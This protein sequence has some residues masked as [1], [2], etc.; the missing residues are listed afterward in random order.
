MK[1]L[2]AALVAALL[3]PQ[4]P[5]APLVFGAQAATIRPAD[6]EAITRAAASYGG[7]PW[8]LT[9][10]RRTPTLSNGERRWVA[11]VYLAASTATPELRRGRLVSVTTA[12]TTQDAPDPMTWKVDDPSRIET[13]AQVT[14]PGRSFDDVQSDSDENKPLV[15]RGE[16]TDADLVSSVR[17]LR[18]RPPIPNPRQLDLQSVGPVR[19]ILAPAF[20]NPS[21]P[22][23]RI[24]LD[25]GNS[26]SWSVLLQRPWNV[27]LQRRDGEWFVESI[28]GGG[29][30]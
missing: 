2:S 14:L 5:P 24:S 17:F 20:L 11:A 18:T 4:V 19:G 12:F 26:C 28:E 25:R 7:T 8:L 27:A 21:L 15:I 22:A 29:C 16:I 10:F 30:A 23:V 9:G 3:A 13:W 1:L 6:I